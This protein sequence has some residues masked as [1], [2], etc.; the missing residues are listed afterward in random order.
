M[1]CHLKPQP[2]A[3]EVLKRLTASRTRAVDKLIPHQT[4]D[5]LNHHEHELGSKT[6]SQEKKA[7]R[8]RPITSHHGI[9]LLSMG[10]RKPQATNIGVATVCE[11][12]RASLGSIMPECEEKLGFE[13]VKTQAAQLEPPPPQINATQQPNTTHPQYGRHS[14]E[15]SVRKVTRSP[16][17]LDRLGRRAIENPMSHWIGSVSC[18]PTKPTNQALSPRTDSRS[19]VGWG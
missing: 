1:R 6:T 8:P 15:T 2:P 5:A 17:R 13:P 9:L 14:I 3:F 10:C 11:V 16:G 12:P 4:K 18:Q 7:L 19:G